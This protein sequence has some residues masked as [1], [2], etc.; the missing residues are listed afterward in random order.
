MNHFLKN[1]SL[2]MGGFIFGGVVTQNA[3]VKA[4]QSRKPFIE[5]V[6]EIGY[7]I[8][9]DTHSDADSVLNTM[10]ELISAYGSASISDLYDLS[11]IVCPTYSAYKYGWTDLD[12]ARVIRVR[13]GYLLKLPKAKRIT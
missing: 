13:D 5:T 6:P 2:F 8:I 3:I 7:D 11:S 4:I 1:I 10:V 9:F 12:L